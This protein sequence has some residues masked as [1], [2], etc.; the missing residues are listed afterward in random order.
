MIGMLLSV[1]IFW[2]LLHS[3]LPEHCSVTNTQDRQQVT[4]WQHWVKL[5]RNLKKPWGS[6]M[7]NIKPVFADRFWH[8]RRKRVVSLLK[9]KTKKRIVEQKLEDMSVN[10]KWRISFVASTLCRVSDYKNMCFSLNP[11]AIILA[12]V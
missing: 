9:R 6:K 8:G 7:L 3:H 11:Q 2:S 5:S 10:I 1:I 12:Q 4:D